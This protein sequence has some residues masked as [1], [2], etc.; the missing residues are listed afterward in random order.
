MKKS[1]VVGLRKGSR[2]VGHPFVLECGR[3]WLV[4]GAGSCT[5]S[6]C[7]GGNGV[8]WCYVCSI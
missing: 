7:V 2:I 1:I 3:W 8:L 4:H 6:V 5:E